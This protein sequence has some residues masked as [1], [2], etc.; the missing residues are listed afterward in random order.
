MQILN[1][2]ANNLRMWWQIK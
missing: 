2:Q 1:S